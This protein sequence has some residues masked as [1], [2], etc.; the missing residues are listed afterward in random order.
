[1]AN[2]KRR[3]G[4]HLLTK[5]DLAT[6]KI[7]LHSDGGCL[8][9]KVA[10][11]G[12]ASWV[13]RYM[14]QGRTRNLGLGSVGTFDLAEARDKARQ[15]RQVLA[16]GGDP[17]A[18]RRE[19]R[20]VEAH[21]QASFAEVAAE[22]LAANRP[23]WKPKHASQVESELKRFAWPLD[24]LPIGEVRRASVLSCIKPLWLTKNSIMAR[25]R[26][27][28]YGILAYAIAHDYR[29]GP[30][31]AEWEGALD[32]LLPSPT[33]VKVKEHFA[34]LP[35]QQLGEFMPRLRAETGELSR[36]LEVA[37]LTA[38]RLGMVVNADWSEMDLDRKVWTI[39]GAK[40]KAGVEHVIP[41]T[42]AAIAAL[43]PRGEG[44]V[45]SL[46]PN[47]SARL[48]VFLR[49]LHPGVT[50][51]G[52]RSTFKTWADEMT[53]FAP[54]VAERALAHAVGNDVERAYNRGQLL[55]KRRRLMEDWAAFCA[56][57]P[58]GEVVAIGAGR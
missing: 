42:D 43:G 38:A 26:S 21:K 45:F 4:L 44:K 31:P 57:P 13:F 20:V 51:H 28:L 1:M 52:F 29:P 7:G 19:Q 34:H 17:M 5:R 8:Y 27:H 25:V 32:Q 24:K 48:N 12:T 33:K 55:E 50:P 35:Y 41:L 11:G 2:A 3:T 39:P 47:E 49:K 40:M 15:L 56:A 18:G 46:K 37:I 53:A 9:L 36:I 10:P 14:R 30:N 16:G 54:D 6:S 58:R 23:G 22:W